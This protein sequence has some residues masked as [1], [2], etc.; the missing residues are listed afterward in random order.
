MCRR[1]QTF[2]PTLPAPRLIVLE[3]PQNCEPLLH[4]RFSD[5]SNCSEHSGTGANFA[6]GYQD[7]YRMI[8][9]SRALL[10]VCE[11]RSPR[12]IGVSSPFWMV[13]IPR[14]SPQPARRIGTSM[15]GRPQESTSVQRRS[16]G[17]HPPREELSSS[18]SRNGATV[19]M[20]SSRDCSDVSS[21]RR[22]SA[23]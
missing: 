23:A 19:S 8:M 3:H 6:N 22:A 5:E 17:F 16:A 11:Y 7:G 1:P 12:R 21:D 20:S 9:Y 10:S 15:D 13:L 14:A 18:R 2:A 4:R